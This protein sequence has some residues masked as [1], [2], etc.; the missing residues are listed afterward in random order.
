M[1]NLSTVLKL[2]FK[3]SPSQSVLIGNLDAGNFRKDIFMK[4]G[5][6]YVPYY[7][8]NELENMFQF[9]IDLFR[10]RNIQRNRMVAHGL[11]VFDTLFFCS[12]DCLV[13]Q[14]NRILCKYSKLPYWRQMTVE[15]GEDLLVAAYLA[16]CRIPENEIRQRGFLWNRVLGHNN[17]QLNSITRRGISENHFHLGGSAPVFH[18]S[19]ISLMNH[20]DSTKVINHLKA[21][22]MNRRYTNKMFSSE[23]REMSFYHRQ[24]QAVLIRLFLYSC[25]TG[26]RIRLGQYLV[27]GKKILQLINLHDCINEKS[28]GQINLSDLLKWIENSQQDIFSLWELF[29]LSYVGTVPSF[30]RTFL[31]KY[32]LCKTDIINRLRDYENLSLEDYIKILISCLK[33]VDLGDID[34]GCVDYNKFNQVWE[35]LTQDNILSLLKNPDKIEDYLVEIQ[36]VIDSLRIPPGHPEAQ[37]DIEIDYLLR[38]T[39]QNNRMRDEAYFVFSGERWFLYS[40]MR[41]IYDNN[42]SDI[43]YS[44]LFY[45][46]ILIK[47]SIRSEIIQS[48][49]NVGFR[50][51]QEYQNRKIDLLNDEIYQNIA[52]KLAMRECLLVENIRTLEIRISPYD[53]VERLRTEIAELDNLIDPTNEYRYRFFYTL[54]FTKSSLKN[55]RHSGGVVKCRHFQKRIKI[56]KQTWAI[57]RLREWYPEIGKRILGIDAA[58]NEIGCRPEVFGRYFRLL[59]HHISVYYEADGMHKM[60]QLKSTYHVG[61]DFL[62]LADGLRA[63]DEMIHFLNF[64]CGD[65][66]G[67]ALA[68]GVNAKE[69]YQSKRNT[70][71]LSAQDYLDN[72]VWVHEKLED[73]SISGFEN[74][75]EFLEDEY[76]RYYEAIYGNYIGSSE[77]RR[78][79]HEMKKYIPDLAE[80]MIPDFSLRTYY[81]SMQLR[82]DDPELYQKGYFDYAEY[83]N[84][85]MEDAI[86]LKVPDSYR[87]TPGIVILYYY[88]HFNN[89]VRREG[90]NNIQINVREDY[91]QAV[92]KIQKAFQKEISRRGIGIETNP[93]SNYLI[94]TFKD[95]KKHPITSF[96][97]L[98]LEVDPDRINECPQLQVSINT[99]DQGVFST[100]LENE[101]ALLAS[102]LENVQDENREYIYK[103]QMIYKWLD[104]IRIMGNEQSFGNEQYEEYFR[105]NDSGNHN[106]N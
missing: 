11:N 14:N 68:L 23:Y 12:D 1:N 34:G 78:I 65:R 58:S 9:Y 36:A 13:I 45:A 74:L 43:L 103:K 53:S 101:Y 33:K 87:H 83:F 95:Y 54:H 63:I 56:E 24:L 51:F 80:D 69:W 21:Y 99:D 98:G 30:F 76:I 67:H 19:W 28:T 73:Y 10:K 20:V 46:Y 75:K 60:P 49:D 89:Y 8:E 26:K 64:D 100:S 62:D 39:S 44:N 31:E 57:I 17:E 106:N 97:N 86:N 59:K 55:E 29:S 32:T 81:L 40:M 105:I 15:L 4:M 84:A 104:N 50:N 7:S 93:S 48:N 52:V 71:I 22:D 41:R 6:A 79:L 70:I 37:E 102:A 27:S 42:E 94:G 72:L 96:Y 2:L 82:G 92:E 77:I 91:I 3:K 5:T 38:Q 66:M 35:K 85:G 25:I 16:Q 90:M 61:E 47:E 18:V 88:Y